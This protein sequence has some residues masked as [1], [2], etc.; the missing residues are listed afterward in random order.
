MK[1]VK[2]D[3]P[4]ER[5][6]QIETAI[7]IVAVLLIGGLYLLFYR[8]YVPHGFDE[9]YHT[10]FA[11]KLFEEPLESMKAEDPDV[12]I[13]AV[14]Y[15]LYHVTLKA[16]AFLLGNRYFEATYIFNAL[17]VIVAIFLIR[18]FLFFA[19][20]EK[21]WKER[22]L[23]DV[24]S[25]CAVVFVTAS[26]PLTGWRMYARQSAANPVHNP[27]VLFVRPFGILVLIAFFSFLKRYE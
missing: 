9:R 10:I 3:M 13:W 18:W 4:K 7:F 2:E 6:V 8:H 21:G 11:E 25:V 19:Y 22:A 17:C 27:T 1:P 24:I 12:P 23:C 15:P 16:M 5:S 26:S 14:T 20:P